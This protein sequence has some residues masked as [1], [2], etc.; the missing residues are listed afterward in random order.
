MT[1]RTANRTT[2]ENRIEAVKHPL[3]AAVLRILDERTASPAEMARELG[4]L[5]CTQIAYH[6]RRLV[7]LGCAELVDERPVRGSVEHFY[8][9]TERHLVDTDEWL[10]LA[11][12][13]PELAS[14]LFGEYGQAIIDD[15]VTAG[16]IEAYK[17][18]K[19]HVTRTPTLLDL[20]GLAK[21]LEIVERMR[22]EMLELQDE[23]LARG[24]RTFTVSSSAVLV[25]VTDY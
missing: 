23:V 2:T 3:R 25:R 8:K 9:G 13:H 19:F 16:K 10:D 4:E 22:M 12:N 14:H 20:E 21:G 15:L 11:A 17:D 5:D 6:T 18:E 7:K 24:G 1:T